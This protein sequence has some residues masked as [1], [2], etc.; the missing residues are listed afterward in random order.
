MP[1]VKSAYLYHNL[2]VQTKVTILSR[3][4]IRVAMLLYE[5]FIL[6]KHNILHPN[7]QYLSTQQHAY[8]SV[9]LLPGLILFALL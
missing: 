2:H 8:R 6:L 9:W 1:L 7:I 3:R 4:L 5:K